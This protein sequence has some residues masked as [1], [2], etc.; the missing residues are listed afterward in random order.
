MKKKGSEQSIEAFVVFIFIILALIFGLI[1]LISKVKPATEEAE[2]KTTCQAS[3]SAHAAHKGLIGLIS[4][5]PSIICPP[6]DLVI[7]EDL[8]TEDG[9]AQAKAEIAEAMVN[10]WEIFGLGKKD[11]FGPNNGRFCTPCYITN[12]TGKAANKEIGGFYNY[13]LTE[14]VPGK[15]QTYFDYLGSYKTSQAGEVLNQLDARGLA[16]EKIL[17]QN[18][19]AVVF[20]YVKGYDEVE[21]LKSDL[22]KLSLS[23]A[24][25]VAGLVFP[26]VREKTNVILVYFGILPEEKAEWISQIYFMPYTYESMKGLECELPVAQKPG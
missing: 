17:T 22:K 15:S 7:D 6:Q 20:F 10:C 13:L 5:K 23:P 16:G 18:T 26:S 8:S 24:L 4:S 14:K 1:L 3:V 19:H 11:L 25:V 9:Q 21:R 2:W 12:F